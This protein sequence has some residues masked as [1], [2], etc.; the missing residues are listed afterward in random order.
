MESVKI[1][2]S[3]GEIFYD[4]NKNYWKA[5]ISW[6]IPCKKITIFG[7]TRALTDK[8][9]SNII[10]KLLNKF[11]FGNYLDYEN[12]IYL[13]KLYNRDMSKK[14][15]QDVEDMSYSILG[16]YI[17]ELPQSDDA[18]QIVKDMRNLFVNMRIWVK[19]SINR[20][21][22][23]SCTLPFK[24]YGKK[25]EMKIFLKMFDSI[26][27][28]FEYYFFKTTGKEVEIKCIE[29]KMINGKATVIFDIKEV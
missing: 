28:E 5:D 3:S 29:S 8:E 11:Y 27:Y 6:N 10:T 24:I 13:C 20:K 2:K 9:R 1:L 19:E 23:I 12:D 18:N 14:E 17:L 22:K 4:D 25:R 15:E 26:A 16:E 21:E 7:T